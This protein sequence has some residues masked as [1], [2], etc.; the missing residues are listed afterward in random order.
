MGNLD[1]FI[2]AQENIYIKALNEIKNGKKTTHWMWYIFPQLKGLG[3]SEMA[4]YYGIDNLLEAQEY[5]NNKL[6]SSR[7]Y[8]ITNELLNLS[9]DNPEK[10][11]G[12]V[13]AMKLRSCMTL[14]NLVSSENIFKDVLEKYYG[15]KV[16]DKT[17]ALCKNSKIN[18]KS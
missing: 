12:Y 1:R 15:G 10:I 6:L 11:F 8:E 5:L 14:F 3:M 7:L 9:E 13:D 18:F 4:N 2:K 16:D 17:I